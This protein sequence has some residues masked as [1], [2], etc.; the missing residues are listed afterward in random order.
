MGWTNF[1]L[2][3]IV[4]CTH[5]SRSKCIRCQKESKWNEH[6]QTHLEKLTFS[7]RVHDEAEL[8]ANFRSI[9][10]LQ[11]T[12]KLSDPV[13]DRL[14]LNSLVPTEQKGNNGNSMGIKHQLLMVK[15]I[16]EKYKIRITN[17]SGLTTKKVLTSHPTTWY[18]NLGK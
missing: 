14:E 9:T 10:C 13:Q 7:K 4:T 6:R 3:I 17:T 8:H 12:F 1:G 18:S 15:I 5:E 16:F 2:N 11:T